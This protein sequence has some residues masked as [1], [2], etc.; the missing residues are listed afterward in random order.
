MS[1]SSQPVSTRVRRRALALAGAV[2]AAL[3]VLAPAA[4]AAPN[5]V[6]LGDSYTAGPLIP[7]QIAPF[8]CLK[9]DRN[10]PHLAAPSIGLP[11]RDPSCSGAETVDMTNPQSVTGGSNPPQF[12]SLAADTRVVTLGIGGN[13]IG[14]TGIIEDCASP[15]PFGRRC[16]N[17]FVVNG[18]DEISAR[19]QATAPK[20]AAVLQGIRQRS[21]SARVFVVN[22]LPI[23]PE[24]GVG[25]WPQLPIAWAD[26]P[27][28]RSKERELNAMLASQA[29][30]AGARL[31]DAYTAG[32]GRDACKGSGTR[33]VEPIVPANLAAPVHPNL[34]GMQGTAAVVA[35][36]VG[37]G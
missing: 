5:Y 34:R 11:L 33:W 15:T 18:R 8:G 26:V 23:F 28:L 24:T 16:Q 6:S 17:R 19:I 14:F 20:V 1:P 13:D 7:N 4:G 22:Y 30:A 36:A 25:C 35:A 31:I 12:N 9:S 10:Y 32:I 2:V 37:P 27:Y 21:A 29:A 3:A